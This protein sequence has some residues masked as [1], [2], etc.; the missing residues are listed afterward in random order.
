MHA[1]SV[2]LG[3]PEIRFL[4]YTTSG[5]SV[6]ERPSLLGESFAVRPW[7]LSCSMHAGESREAPTAP[8]QAVDGFRGSGSK[9]LPDLGPEGLLFYNLP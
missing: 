8:A 5:P 9:V 1:P 3:G 2:P 6:L 7:C 4:L